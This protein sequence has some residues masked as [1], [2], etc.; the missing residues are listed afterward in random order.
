MVKDTSRILYEHLPQPPNPSPTAYVM[1]GPPDGNVLDM[2]CFANCPPLVLSTRSE[3]T[4]TRAA[5]LLSRVGNT[6]A[7][8]S[9][10]AVSFLLSAVL[11]SRSP[12]DYSKKT[13]RVGKAARS[14]A[15]E[16]TDPYIFRSR[17]ACSGTTRLIRQGA[18]SHCGE[19]MWWR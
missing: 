16:L 9:D 19:R 13:F 1:R 18:R 6:R 12:R 3:Q 5:M 17:E 7:K 2:I 15:T 11:A 10:S 4:R 8:P 14:T